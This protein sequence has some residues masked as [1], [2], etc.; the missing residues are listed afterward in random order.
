MA[1]KPISS[2]Y[3]WAGIGGAQNWDLSCCRRK[4][5]RLCQ[6]GT[7]KEML[8]RFETLAFGG[9][10]LCRRFINLCPVCC[11]FRVVCMKSHDMS[12][13]KWK[14]LVRTRYD[15]F[16]QSNGEVCRIARRIRMHSS[17]MRTARSLTV[18]CHILCMP[19]SNHTHPPATMHAPQQ[20]CIPPQPSTPCNHACPPCS[21]TPPLNHACPPTTVHAPCNHTPPTTTHAPHNYICPTATTHPPTTTHTPATVHTPQQPHTPPAAMHIPCNHAPPCNHACPPTTHAPSWTEWQTGVKILPCPKLRLR[22]VKISFWCNKTEASGQWLFYY[23][24]L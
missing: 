4:L 10:W 8:S 1:A 17:R 15:R 11:S 21:H 23:K 3:L 5:Y 9:L 20:P 12:T 14:Q 22:A 24:Q 2:M 16:F 19:P 7:K 13:D 18:S 6:L